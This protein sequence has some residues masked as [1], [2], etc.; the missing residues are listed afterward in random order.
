MKNS[1]IPK[2]CQN[3]GLAKLFLE[4]LLLVP[5][6]FYFTRTATESFRRL[7]DR[8]SQAQDHILLQNRLKIKEVTNSASENLNRKDKNLNNSFD[9]KFS[10]SR[11]NLIFFGFLI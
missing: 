5:L 7:S 10:C 9:V 8:F 2:L 1:K 3:M 11:G 6:E 4:K